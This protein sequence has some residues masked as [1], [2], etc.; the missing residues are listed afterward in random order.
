MAGGGEKRG[1]EGDKR[2]ARGERGCVWWCGRSSTRAG[3]PAQRTPYRVLVYGQRQ[4]ALNVMAPEYQIPTAGP[5]QSSLGSVQG[6]RHSNWVPGAKKPILQ[7]GPGCHS[8][9][10]PYAAHGL[11]E[12]DPGRLVRV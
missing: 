10:A 2:S 9:R 11:A 1:D 3:L 12:T 4:T 6:T 8:V 5:D 7:R